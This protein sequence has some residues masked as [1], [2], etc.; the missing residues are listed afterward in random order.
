M[1]TSLTGGAHHLFIGRCRTHGLKIYMPFYLKIKMN[2]ESSDNRCTLESMLET[3]QHGMA[4]NKLMPLEIPMS[5]WD[6]PYE[7]PIDSARWVISSRNYERFR[8]ISLSGSLNMRPKSSQVLRELI[9]SPSPTS[10]IHNSQASPFSPDQAQNSCG[11]PMLFKC[12][13]GST[14]EKKDDFYDHYS[15]ECVSNFNV[16]KICDR[17]FTRKQDLNNHLPSHRQQLV[18]CDGCGFKFSKH[19]LHRHKNHCIK[20]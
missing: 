18:T 5:K 20:F 6:I 16:C 3:F 19:Q 14:F 12:V 7:S 1:G 4:G 13:C 17:G 8:P 11:A 9:I 2:Q 10:P 15:N